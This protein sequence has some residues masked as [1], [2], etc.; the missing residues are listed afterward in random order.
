[1]SLLNLLQYC[2]CF[3]LWFFGPKACGIP[4]PRL[5]IKPVP[6]ASEGDVVTAG[7]PG[8]SL[9]AAVHLSSSGGQ[10][11]TPGAVQQAGEEPVLSLSRPGPL[12]CDLAW[13]LG[14][15]RAPS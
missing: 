2:F 8:K 5:G 10:A 1:M 9:P 11:D 15:D 4:T 6:S 12:S 14:V 3:M 13:K 7:P